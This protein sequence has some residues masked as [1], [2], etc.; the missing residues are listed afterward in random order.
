M[1]PEAD[2]KTAAHRRDSSGGETTSQKGEII[3]NV[4]W[5]HDTQYNNTE[6]DTQ[7]N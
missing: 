3:S 2:F 6:H 5:C 7:R 4:F 1:T